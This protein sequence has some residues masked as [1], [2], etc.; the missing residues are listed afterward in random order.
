M[1]PSNLS[2]FFHCMQ[3]ALFIIQ[4]YTTYV[5]FITAHTQIPNFAILLNSRELQTLWTDR[6]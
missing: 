4:L 6:F 1:T 5:T 2:C 3:I